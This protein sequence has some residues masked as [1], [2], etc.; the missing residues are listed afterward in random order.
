LSKPRTGAPKRVAAGLLA[1]ALTIFGPALALAPSAGAT[2]AVTTSRLAGTN[3]YGTAAAIASDAS[4]GTPSS[5]IVA[6]GENYP[7]ALAAAPLAGANGPAP[8]VLTATATL[9][10]E[11]KTALNS[12]KSK[13][14]TS[15]S[16]VGGTAAVSTDT[17]NAI[18]ALGLGTSRIAGADR[19]ATASSIAQAANAKSPSLA[20]GGL[21]TALIATGTNFPDALAGGPA[22]YA[23]KLPILLVSDT[24]PQATKD[25]ISAMGIKKAVILGGT[26]AVSDAVKTQL[27]SLTGNPSDRLAG[28]NRNG[29]AAAVGDYEITTLLFGASSAVLATGLN[30]PDALAAG[31]LGGQNRA[32]IVLTASLP[33]ESQ[34]WLDKN[35]KTISKLYVSGGTSAID[36]ATVTAAQTA[37]Q[38]TSNDTGGTSGT[39]VTD[40]PELLNAT[41]VSQVST[42]TASVKFTFDSAVSGKVPDNTK[43]HLLTNN[44][45]SYTPTSSTLGQVSA[46]D[47][48]SVI[49]I[50]PTTAGQL[51]SV[52]M[53]TVDAD[54]VRDTSAAGG[55]ANPEGAAGMSSFSASAGQTAAPDLQSIGNYRADATGTGM[56]FDLTFDANAYVVGGRTTGV[57]TTSTYPNIHIVYAST[58]SDLVVTDDVTG[59]GTKTLTFHVSDVGGGTVFDANATTISNLAIARAYITAGGIADA[60]PATVTNP[61]EMAVAGYNGITDSPD[62]VSATFT[63]NSTNT[64]G[65]AV[66]KVTYT[67]D[68]PVTVTDATKFKVYN[69]DASETAAPAA[70]ATVSPTDNKSV[71]VNFS[72]GALGSAVGASV[73]SAAVTGTTGSAKTNVADAVPVA[74]V[75]FQSDRTD[76]PD[77][78]GAV[79]ATDTTDAFSGAVTGYKLTYSFDEK[80]SAVAT[81]ASFIVYG[82]TTGTNG[83]S[84]LNGGGAGCSVTVDA[85]NTFNVILKGCT[86]V[87]GKP[88]LSPNNSFLNGGFKLATVKAGAVTP[89]DAGNS[90]P[91][92]A[93]PITGP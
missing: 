65:T 17:E 34:A 25:A 54:A 44:K 92:G 93:E 88:K 49:A 7:D 31:P 69:V 39:S 41:F 80:L 56:L 66:D 60:N 55:R 59:Q 3:R 2:T 57:F 53:A 36:D 70:S 79:L 26:A 58:S 76:G 24:V 11:A 37:A 64:A 30:F 32:P 9:S 72:A 29:T 43:F 27:D 13:G 33:A 40:A 62:L 50:F 71:V 90:N 35:S 16:I 63:P 14:V 28:T 15:V 4:F 5:A 22:A 46:S 23:N 20:I 75:T 83:A 18:K 77:L 19:Y 47:N 12:L 91:I 87:D 85:T 84:F 74:G 48:N 45:T 38:T 86:G 68:E 73:L 8:I 51:A 10:D 6:T 42:T 82:G 61:L 81:A 21:K 89:A 78:T 1:G 67:F 52:T